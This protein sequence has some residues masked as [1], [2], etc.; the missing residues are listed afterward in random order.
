MYILTK[1][2]YIVGCQYIIETNLIS[3]RLIKSGAIFYRDMLVHTFQ[4]LKGISPKKE[5]SLWYSGIISWE[6]LES[7][8]NRQLPLFKDNGWNNSSLYL[9]KKALEKGDT[10]YFARLLPSQE[11]YRIALT[12][13]EKT[14]FLDIETTG[15]SKY[16]DTITLVGW[17][18]G[19]EYNVFIKGDKDKAFRETISKAKAIVTFNGSLFDLPFLRKEFPDLSIPMCHIDLRFLS[20]RVGLS[21]GQKEIE[22]LI[23]IKRPKSISNVKGE[24]AAL[25]W[26]KYRWGDLSALRQLISYNH[27]DIEGMKIIYD[28]VVGRLFEKKQFPVKTRSIH[29]FSKNRSKINWF[30]PE[31]HNSKGIRIKQYKETAPPILL[32]DLISRA[33]KNPLRIVGIDLTGSESRPSGWCL[34]EGTNAITERLGSDS[35]IIRETVKAQPTLVSIDSPLSI[36]AGRTSVYDDDPGRQDFGIMRSCERILKKRGVNVYPSLIPSMQKLTARGIRLANQ[37]RSMGIPVIESFPG[38]AQDI[39]GIPRKRV[40]Q[41]FLAK[42]LERFGVKGDFIKN[43]IS[44]DELDAITSAVVGLF[45]WSGKFEALGNIEEEYLIIPNLKTD[46]TTWKGRKVIGLSGPIAAGK[47]TAG[48]FLRAKGFH[49]GRFS[50]VLE[51]ILRD[52]GLQVTRENLQQI[53]E[54]VHKDPGQRWLCHRLIQMLSSQGDI[55]IDGLRHPEDHSYLV[56]TFGPAFLHIYIDAPQEIL[57][58]RYITN[59]YSKDD[60][61]MAISH[62][63]EKNV[64]RLYSLAHIVINNT[65]SIN[66]FKQKI[67]NTV[68]KRQDLKENAFACR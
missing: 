44:H 10:N 19:S 48:N 47:T 33:N 34:L 55:V 62:P 66:V 15:L 53:G 32:H 11:Y 29:H 37:F 56:E 3:V 27:A 63:V 20:R 25:L 14:L 59:G 60:F 22:R 40:S 5:L 42:G 23:G 18:L 50:L 67:T 51:S 57:L 28:K 58:E 45:F 12:F 30:K 49:Y 43:P 39:M 36:P 38:A 46:P 2:L 13:P 7:R 17:S 54:E 1:I 6:D 9:S 65:N 41:E 52:R 61:L 24:T 4:H 8:E 16:Y 31:A 35:E 68:Y 26:Y 21:G 64:S